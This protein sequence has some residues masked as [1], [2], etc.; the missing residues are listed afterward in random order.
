MILKVK[1]KIGKEWRWGVPEKR[2][3]KDDEKEQ[4][5]SCY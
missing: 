4:D 5:A 3:L 1:R 2:D